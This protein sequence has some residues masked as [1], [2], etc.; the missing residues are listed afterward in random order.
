M[1]RRRSNEVVCVSVLITFNEQHKSRLVRKPE[2]QGPLDFSGHLACLVSYINGPACVIVCNPTPT[3]VSVHQ[4]ISLKTVFSYDQVGTLP[5]LRKDHSEES[6]TR[7]RKPHPRRCVHRQ[8]K[9]TAR[10]GFQLIHSPQ[11]ISSRVA[12]PNK[13]LRLGAHKRLNWTFQLRF[14][15]GS[16]ATTAFKA[17]TQM[18][19]CNCTGKR[20]MNLKTEYGS[21]ASNVHVRALPDML[22]EE[23]KKLELEELR[24]T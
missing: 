1:G 5:H 11:R 2:F 19:I 3:A 18:S 20:N 7:P 13:I 10:C 12:W 8:R 16:S 4:P 14:R 6:A 24:T 9:N 23:T 17:S 21:S 15:T 22:Q